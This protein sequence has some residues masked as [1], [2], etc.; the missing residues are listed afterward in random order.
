M[1]LTTVI[2]VYAAALSTI[3]LVWQLYMWWER[4][5]TRVE[6]KLFE[7]DEGE[8]PKELWEIVVVQVTNHSGHDIWINNIS[9]KA[10]KEDRWTS[11]DW[12]V[13]WD[14]KKVPISVAQGQQLEFACLA[15][16][17]ATAVNTST[18]VVA[19]VRLGNNSIHDS[20]PNQDQSELLIHIGSASM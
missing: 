5:R 12:L 9:L 6:V 2:A 13:R 10:V 18:P 8:Y 3:G 1:T 7:D 19:R 16:N 15:E 14:G 11:F 17:V 20:R 4:Q